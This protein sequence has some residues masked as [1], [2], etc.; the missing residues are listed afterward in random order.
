LEEDL[1]AISGR[2]AREPRADFGR[3]KIEVGLLDI[4][5]INAGYDHVVGRG[6][7]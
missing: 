4:V 5:A 1:P 3:G 7:Q 2:I 6:R